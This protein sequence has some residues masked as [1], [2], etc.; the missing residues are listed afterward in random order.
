MSVL[1][2]FYLKKETFYP[3]VLPVQGY[4]K[5]NDE[6]TSKTEIFDSAVH[7]YTKENDCKRSEN[8]YFFWN[9][10][11]TYTNENHWKRSINRVFQN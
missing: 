8:G 2:R 7:T 10:I 6:S 11:H 5:K 4:T 9:A 1:N 3:I